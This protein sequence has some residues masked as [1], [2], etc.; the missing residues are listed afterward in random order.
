MN[1]L[2]VDKAVA[3][4]AATRD[5][6]RN[7]VAAC[8]M[9]EIPRFIIFYKIFIHKN[10]SI[11]CFCHILHLA[12]CDGLKTNE[13]S[14]II[15]KANDIVTFF[16]NS[17][18]ET[19][20]FRAI[21]GDVSTVFVKA[22]KTRWNS[23]LE[24]I[25]SLVKHRENLAKYAQTNLISRATILINLLSPAD[26]ETLHSLIKILQPFELCTKMASAENSSG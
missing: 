26:F 14:A 3:V 8:R 7:M 22:C 10:L 11:W 2:S 1:S 18:T 13:Y 24:M 15:K 17:P 20:I 19:A 6:A 16:A 5:G 9:A 12:I 21:Q 23:T 4:V 25:K